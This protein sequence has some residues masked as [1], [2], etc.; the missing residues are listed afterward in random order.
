MTKHPIFACVALV[1]LVAA[2][3][4]AAADQF[5]RVSLS[6]ITIVKGAFPEPPTDDTPGRNARDWQQRR[7]RST[8]QLPFALAGNGIEAYVT[9]PNPS[10]WWSGR[11]VA[12]PLADTHLCARV[13]ADVPPRVTLVVPTADQSGMVQL[14][15][16]L[17]PPAKDQAA[18]ATAFQSAREA[19]Y[20]RLLQ[21]RIPGAAW[22]RHQ[23]RAAR[24]AR[25]GLTL[26]GVDAPDAPGPNR[27][28]VDN[29]ELNQTINLF[30]GGRAISENLQLDRELRIRG[31]GTE[32]TIPLDTI[33]G[34]TTAEI[35]WKPLLAD[36]NPVLDVLAGAVP[37]DQYACFFQSFA[38]LVTIIDTAETNGTPILRLLDER[39]EDARSRSRYEY[40]LCMKLDDTARLL[41]PKVIKTVAFTGSDPFFRTGTDLAVL[42]TAEN[43]VVLAGLLA[44]QHQ[45]A[46]LTRAN[47]KRET[48]TILG[49]QYS[50]VRSPD[51]RTCSYLC[52]AGDVVIVTNSI[53][54][55][56]RILATRK[57][58][59]PA[60]ATADEF[61][62]FRD[63][64]PCA[65]EDE[66]GL[67]V[68]SD[69]AIRRLCS[70]RWR[71]AASRR[72][73]AAAVMAE[74]QARLLPSLAGAADSKPQL[75]V[76]PELGELTIDAH[77]LRSS[78]YGSLDFLTPIAELEIGAVTKPEADAYDWFRRSYQNQ[79]RQFFDPIAVRFT[80]ADG[81][82]TVDVTV[83]PLIASSDYRE[84]M[85]VTGNAAIKPG[86]GDPHAGTLLQFIMS[87]DPKS[88]PV[89]QL[90]NMAVMMAPGLE[91]NA[92]AWLGNWISLYVEQDPV[93]QELTE[94]IEKEGERAMEDF[95]QGNFSRLPIAV[96]VDVANS[97]K[98]T[99]FLASARAFIEQTAPD[100][101]NWQ[102]IKHGTRSYVKVT[103]SQQALEDMGDGE[104]GMR[105]LAVCYAI[106][107]NGFMLTLNE[108]LLKQAMDRAMA[109]PAEDS[110]AAKAPAVT[111]LGSS[112]AVRATAPVFGI[113]RSLYGQQLR[114]SM[115]RRS[116]D[117]I[118]ALNEWRRRFQVED[119]VAFHESVW[120]TRL[121][122]PGGGDYV[123]NAELQTMEST[124]FGSPSKPLEKPVFADPLLQMRELALGLTFEGDGLR[125]KAHLVPTP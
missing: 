98:L 80:V 31:D 111:W 46:L 122:C 113:L 12:A 82:T 108:G 71:I 10:Q 117:N 72:V 88:G 114:V 45:K 4:A 2:N 27:P 93:W 21:N 8:R 86:D 9:V 109:A 79:W 89:Q 32:R 49:T 7:N 101:T 55:L 64:Y 54:Q 77:G 67:L 34:I 65:A 58:T 50:G 125:A 61:R 112:V 99:A 47:V 105:D 22:Y 116:W 18:A 94:L 13:P 33:E 62:F 60:L 29:S 52:T 5:H 81:T 14:V 107:P 25:E 70:P 30:S 68:L 3:Q 69:S 87:L 59:Q 100:M 115:E 75:P 19:H 84:F 103:P 53:S 110:P 42:F 37:I 56:E 121:A 44:A 15:V 85:A 35:D 123:W 38:D 20:Q 90:G 78:I 11:P 43:P 118:P 63:R 40:Q 120:G 74:L 17:G 1:A 83:R 102:A 96:Q 76:S 28:A 24:A 6:T 51:R 36:K 91:A 104:E 16:D 92:L 41:G 97:F 124:V 119:P 26:D 57:G 48:G 73:R 106:L 95:L 23:V 66:T 39:S